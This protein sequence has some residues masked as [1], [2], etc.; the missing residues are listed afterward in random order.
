MAPRRKTIFTKR[1]D[2]AKN[3]RNDTIF[4]EVFAEP[5]AKCAKLLNTE[6]LTEQGKYKN[7][8]FNII[9]IHKHCL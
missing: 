5:P 9:R 3:K 6:N 8:V 1:W 4:E 7:Y 2:S